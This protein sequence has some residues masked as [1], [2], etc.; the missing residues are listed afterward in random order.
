MTYMMRKKQHFVLAY[1]DDYAGTHSGH[2]QALQGYTD[3]MALMKELG[4]KLAEHKC[5][6]PAQKI[7]WLGFLVDTVQMTIAVPEE[8]LKQV[9]NECGKWT[10]KKRANKKMIQSILGKLIYISACVNQ[11]RKFVA[12]ILDTLR[13]MGPK[14]WTWVNQEFKKD[15]EWFQ[16][17]AAMSNGIH[18]YRIDRPSIL[19]ECD[20]STSGAGGNS[21]PFCYSWEYTKE[22]TDR[23]SAIHQLEAVNIVVAF[24]TLAHIHDI[25]SAHVTILT[26]N[27]ASSCALQTGKTKD[28]VLASCSREL[29]LEAARS[30]LEIT[31]QHKPGAELILADALSRRHAD[32]N[33][34]KLADSI[35]RDNHM[36]VVPAC[37]DNYVFF[38]IAL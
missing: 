4:L 33:K 1:L 37:I 3:L 12:R 2:L 16:R 32:K 38:T 14:N 15:I 6:P 27:S 35:I 23:F 19:I 10:S 34:A 11:G 24:R 13:A 28:L 9:L 21:G 22:H 31:I 17:Y 30:D 20:S 8:K 26:D 18:L 29:W 7:E 36:I 25:K 5:L